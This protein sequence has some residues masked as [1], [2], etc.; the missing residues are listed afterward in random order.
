MDLSELCGAFWNRWKGCLI[1]R[2]KAGYENVEESVKRCSLIKSGTEWVITPLYT[3][4]HIQS[5]K[6]NFLFGTYSI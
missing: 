6:N 2:L 3:Y 4:K 1:K 5:L